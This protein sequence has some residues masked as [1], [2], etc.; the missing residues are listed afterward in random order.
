MHE[1]AYNE[2]AFV[3]DLC[4][5]ACEL[6]RIKIKVISEAFMGKS[7]S[8]TCASSSLY[9]GVCYV[10]QVGQSSRQGEK[11]NNEGDYEEW[12]V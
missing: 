7:F 2:R 3:Y 6:H 8:S 11:K 5:K 9:E 10:V 12:P 4:G 1:S